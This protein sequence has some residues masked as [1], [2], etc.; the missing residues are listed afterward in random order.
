[1]AHDVIADSHVLNGRPLAAVV[2]HCQVYRTVASTPPVVLH[3]IAVNG[4]VNRTLQLENVFYYPV[5]N[6][7]AAGRLTKRG[8]G[9]V[10]TQRF[11][12]II[13]LHR[14]V[15]GHESLNAGTR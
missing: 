2:P 6:R 10:P 5:V 9:V 4:D 8:P 11:K 1:M 15:G 7:R 13:S 14:N 3:Y 12:K